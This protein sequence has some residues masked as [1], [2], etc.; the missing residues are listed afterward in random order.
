VL[1]RAVLLAIA[2]VPLAALPAFGQGSCSA[3]ELRYDENENLAQKLSDTNKD[4]KHDEF[5][6]YIDGKP[7]RAER[8]TDHNGQIDV[9]IFFTEDAEPARQEQDTSGDGKV[10]RWDRDEERLRKSA[11]AT[12]QALGASQ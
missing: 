10:D 4:C 3:V 6:F 7:E 8:D 12:Q 2:L 1:A 5:V 11:L 9:W